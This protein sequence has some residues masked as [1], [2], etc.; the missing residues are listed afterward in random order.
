MFARR[1]VLAVTIALISLGIAPAAG[2][3]DARHGHKGGDFQPVHRLAGS[4]AGELLAQWW[5]TVLTIPAA[6]NPINAE[7]PA[8]CFNIGRRD[9]VATYASTAETVECTITAGQRLFLTTFGAE[10]SS[11]E[12]P[13]FFGATEAE[14]RACVEEFLADQEILAIRLSLNG[15]RP[16]DVHNERFE[17]IS[18]QGNVVFP[19]AAIFDAEPGPATFVAADWVATTRHRLR[20]GQHTITLEIELIDETLTQVVTLN[21]LPRRGHD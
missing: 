20:P 9:K 3:H 14:Q 11:A 15:G 1:A 17:V 7:N 12:P 13:P 16:Q 8:L 6:Q 10:C 18:R 4:P 5:E 2:A 21:V 19:E